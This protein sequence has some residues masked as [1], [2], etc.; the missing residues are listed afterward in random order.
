MQYK[1]SDS[2][3]L[4]TRAAL[5][6]TAYSAPGGRPM[7]RYLKRLADKFEASA[8]TVSLKPKE[9]ADVQKLLRAYRDWLASSEVKE[10]D[11]N[12]AKRDEAVKELGEVIEGLERENR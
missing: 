9:A 12:A 4:R 6:H 1:F 2:K 5:L 7:R 10:G 8:Q 11:E 3:L